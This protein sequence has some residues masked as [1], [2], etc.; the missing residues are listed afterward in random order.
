MFLIILGG[1]A[2]FFGWTGRTVPPGAFG[3]MR[4]KTHG[5][6]KRVIREGEFNWVW[7]TLIPGN[8]EVQVFTLDMVSGSINTRD[9]L[10]SG[11]VY[12]SF[13][14]LDA[15]FSYGLSGNHSFTLKPDSLFSLME[16]RHI[17]DQ[18]GLNAYT[19]EVSRELAAF[20]LQRLRVLMEDEHNITELLETGTIA[21][22]GMD[23]GNAFPRIEHF[24]CMFH[25]VDFPDLSLYQRLRGLY[26]GYVNHQK[27]Y[28]SER[29]PENRAGTNIRFSD[30]ARYG[31]LLT[32]YPVLLQY[33]ELE[34]RS[35]K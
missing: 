20:A 11:S 12:A 26:E 3:I 32:K 24:S 27:E 21:Q 34:S 15:D 18:K 25:T 31:E 1:A 13:A 28:V 33:L 22:L 2:L 4:S 17:V 14:G 19:Q 35:G 23:I 8:A 16:E 5:L 29:M 30:L 10:P 9:A 6:E 7:Y